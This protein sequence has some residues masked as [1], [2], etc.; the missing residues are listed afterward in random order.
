[1]NVPQGI[2]A[3]FQASRK[4]ANAQ[5]GIMPALM[6]GAPAS[7]EQIAEAQAI[8]QQQAPQ[9]PTRME[10]LQALGQSVPQRRAARDS[11]DTPSAAGAA[12]RSGATDGA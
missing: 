8:G 10:L 1:M 7:P 12:V 9:A 3:Q 4:L 6:G 5:G 2:P 11:A